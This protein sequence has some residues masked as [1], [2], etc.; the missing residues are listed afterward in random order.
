MINYYSFSSKA[1]KEALRMNAEYDVVLS[2]QTSPVMMARP[3]LAFGEKHN[4]PVLLWCQDL[5]PESLTVGNI[6]RTS[7]IFKG[8]ARVSRKIY[9]AATVL[10]VTSRNFSDYF[11]SDIEQDEVRLYEA[12]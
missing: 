4:V 7:L 3:A 5:W 8:Y 10:A 12:A 1:T 6:K 11:K 2:F 9:N